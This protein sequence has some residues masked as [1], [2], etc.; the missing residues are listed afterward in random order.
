MQETSSIN[1]PIELLK[2]EWNNLSSME[3][4]LVKAYIRQI[5]ND[6]VSF[7]MVLEINKIHEKY[8]DFHIGCAN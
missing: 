7:K 8:P 2:E 6:N 3:K 1:R 5:N 4:S